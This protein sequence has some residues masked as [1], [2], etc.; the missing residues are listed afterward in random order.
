MGRTIS[1]AQFKPAALSLKKY[2]LVIALFLFSGLNAFAQQDS[3]VYKSTVD[4]VGL[5]TD[6]TGLVASGFFVNG[7]TFI[8]NYHVSHELNMDSTFIDMKDGRAFTVKTV[9]FQSYEKDLAIL[10]TY[11][12]SSNFLVLAGNSEIRERQLVYSIGNPTDE[13]FTT[14]YYA[15]TAGRINDIFDDVWHYVTE[16]RDSPD[17]F[18]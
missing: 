7:N 10:E 5:I 18:H 8:T 4:A 9:I 14:S 13:D 1:L 15:L 2:Y 12:I 17:K 6:N 16:K 11:E 3:A